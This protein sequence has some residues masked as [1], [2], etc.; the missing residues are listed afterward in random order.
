[1]MFTFMNQ[2][3]DFILNGTKTQTRRRITHYKK[4]PRTGQEVS[5]KKEGSFQQCRRTMLGKAF[6]IVRITRRWR[7]RLCDISDADAMA[8]GHYTKED[9]IEGVVNMYGG[10]L[11]ATDEMWCYEFEL[12]KEVTV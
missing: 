2:H 3:V 10:K 8:E 6:A 12:A 11:N 4:G 9:Y 1:M 7:E 5:P